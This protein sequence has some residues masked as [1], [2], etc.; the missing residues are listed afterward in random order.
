MAKRTL[1]FRAGE[2]GDSAGM[3]PRG[4]AEPLT[5]LLRRREG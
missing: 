2:C 1:G 3:E 5:L 4:V